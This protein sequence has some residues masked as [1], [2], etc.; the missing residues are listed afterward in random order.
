[1]KRRSAGCTASVNDVTQVLGELQAGEATA[2]ERLFPLVSAELHALAQG[3][4]RRQETNPLLQPTMLVDEA[5]MRLVPL[6][7]VAWQNRGHFHAMAARTMRQILCDGSRSRA[8]REGKRERSSLDELADNK[9][10]SPILVLEVDEA[11]QR[12]AL[13][14][15][16]W[17][18]IVEL[19]FFD[20]LTLEETAK[21]LGVCLR[22][23][24]GEWHFARLWLHEALKP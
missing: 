15:E 18:K 7:H 3:Y 9:M 4:L 2:A 14:N 24:E 5:F 13:L 17:A 16:R 1:M 20:G 22:T 11:L 19:R 6:S 21:T 10:P 23:V 12:L 8:A